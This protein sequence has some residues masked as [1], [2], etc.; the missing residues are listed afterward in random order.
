MGSDERYGDKEWLGFD[1]KDFE[2]V[3]DLGEATAVKEVTL[4]FFNSPG[5][6][7]YP[8][9]Q[10]SVAVSTDGKSYDKEVEKEVSTAITDKIVTV[11]IALS[12]KTPRYLKVKAQNLGTIPSGKQG[13]GERAWLFVDEI[14]VK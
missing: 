1:G 11:K 12:G 14:V 5:Q 9:K 10:A 6:W 2:A 3:I 8:P 13:A 4:R 7:I